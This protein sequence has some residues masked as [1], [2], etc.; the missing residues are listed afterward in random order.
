MGENKLTDL[1]ILHTHRDIILN[2]DD[3]IERFAKE[4]KTSTRFHII[5][6]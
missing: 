5:Y 2:L 4:K 3:I 1:A 6:A